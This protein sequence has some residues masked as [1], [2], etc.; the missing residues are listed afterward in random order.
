MGNPRVGPAVSIP[1][2]PVTPL[3]STPASGSRFG[4]LVAQ[5]RTG[6]AASPA[7][8]AVRPPGGSAP[9][10]PAAT[11]GTRIEPGA[12][13]PL[14]ELGRQLLA[15]VARGERYMENVVRQGLSGGKTYTNEELLAL[16][17]QV[18]RYTQEL[19][20]VS[21]LVDRGTS[22]VKTVLQQNG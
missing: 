1:T 6:G 11:P 4:E 17:A 15:R 22:T 18:Y 14:T 21:K 16:Q 20:L 19:E 2:P 7:A 13:Q 5:L 10:T 8:S 3:P 9:L 12:A